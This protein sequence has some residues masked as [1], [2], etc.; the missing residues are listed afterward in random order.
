LVA[1]EG[2]DEDLEKEPTRLTWRR[3]AAAA[4]AVA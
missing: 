2:P 3:A 4:A 1:G